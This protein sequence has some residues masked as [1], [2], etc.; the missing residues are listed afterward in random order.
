MLQ[1]IHL[2][3]RWKE[4]VPVHF[5]GQEEVAGVQLPLSSLST[6][7]KKIVSAVMDVSMVI[8]N[9]AKKNEIN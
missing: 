8:K 4:S 7:I 3:F 1:S 9:P 5:V 2:I 6:P